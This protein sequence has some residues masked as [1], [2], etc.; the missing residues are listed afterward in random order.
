MAAT[1]N[2]TIRSLPANL[3]DYARGWA[4]ALRAA[5]KA[6]RTQR[7]YIG[8][9]RAFAAFLESRGMPTDPTAVTGEHVREFLVDQGERLSPAT[10]RA[11][12]AYLSVFFNWLVQEGELRESPMRR[13]KPP[14]LDERMPDILSDDHYMKLL[15]ACA[16]THLTERRDLAMIRLLEETGMRR[17]EC[18]GLRLE[19]VDLDEMTATVMG[20]GRRIRTVPFTAETAL[21]LSRYLRERNRTRW[22]KR[23]ELWIGHVGPITPNAIGEM[24]ERRSKQAGI[25]RA[26]PHALRHRFADR[27]KRDG[28]S[29]DALMSL[30][31]W[32]N[33]DVMARYGRANEARRAIEEYRRLRGES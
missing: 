1:L 6:E 10:A 12:H 19:D 32:R 9:L 24:L 5:R 4:L 11:R 2:P 29:E 31:G 27:W 7:L 8:G 30:G 3:A 16:G 18:A 25:P 28:G 23:P 26:H 15:R 13:I 33:R 20:K 21:A 22:A 14:A 17:A